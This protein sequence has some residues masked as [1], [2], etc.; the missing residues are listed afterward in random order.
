[1]DFLDKIK[2]TEGVEGEGGLHTFLGDFSL[3]KNSF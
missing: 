3:N 1:M 2:G